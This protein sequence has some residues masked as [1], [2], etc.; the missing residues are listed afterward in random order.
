MGSDGSAAG[1]GCS[2]LSEWQRAPQQAMILL[3][4]ITSLSEGGGSDKSLPE[5]VYFFH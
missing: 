3:L 2:D 1:G 5:G 4:H